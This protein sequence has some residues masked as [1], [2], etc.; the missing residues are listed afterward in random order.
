LDEGRV[1]R[2][3]KNHPRTPGGMAL[4]LKQ[5][6]LHEEKFFK[7]QTA[8]GLQKFFVGLGEV[9]AADGFRAVT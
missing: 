9:D 6:Q 7:H 8:A 4:D 3:I 2:V 5:R 1:I